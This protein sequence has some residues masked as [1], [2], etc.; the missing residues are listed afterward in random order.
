VIYPARTLYPTWLKRAIPFTQRWIDMVDR[1]SLS[2]RRQRER[3]RIAL[4]SPVGGVIPSV[5]GVLGGSEHLALG[6]A[7]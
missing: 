4:A 5:Q 1:L 3:D 2:S 7:R 6:A